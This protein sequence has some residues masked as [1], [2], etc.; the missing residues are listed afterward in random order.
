MKKYSKGTKFNDVL[1]K[2]VIGSWKGN[3][4]LDGATGCGK[5]YFVEHNLHEDCIWNNKNILLLL[6]VI[7]FYKW[8]STKF[9]DKMS[10]ISTVI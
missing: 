10:F 7:L 9:D 4:I 1:T 5:T 8:I 6:S 2:E 3:V